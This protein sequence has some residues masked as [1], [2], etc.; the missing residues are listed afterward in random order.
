MRKIM[1]FTVLTAIAAGLFSSCEW[2]ETDGDGSGELRLRF[3]DRDVV[4]TRAATDIPDTNDFLLTVRSS[5]GKTLYEGA[6]GASPE[7]LLAAAGTYTV[8]AVSREFTSPSFSAPVYG[9]EQVVVVPSGGVATV[10]LTCRQ[11]NCGIKLSIGSSFLTSYPKGVLYVQSDKTHR[12]MYAYTEKRIAYFDPGTISVV[13]NDS[14]V[15]STLLSRSLMSQE[16]LAL[17]I[18]AG[19]S[20]GNSGT[21]T[22][23][24]GHDNG[25]LS[26]VVD[27]TRNWSSSSYILGSGEVSDSE[28]GKSSTNAY[29]VAGAKENIGET[30]V[31]V[32]GYIVGGDMTSSASGMKTEGPFSSAT[33]IAI[34]G[35]SSVTDKS[36][37]LSV[38]LPSGDIREALNLVNNPENLGKR[39]IIKGDLVASY[40]GVPGIKNPTD[41]VLK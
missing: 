10:E 33:N 27:T 7:S 13:L 24:E 8:K 34:A 36:S 14:G 32:S 25:G 1:V 26:I 22:G 17:S 4:M 21:A 16:I 31:W 12:L 30:E 37:C 9:D 19:T 29:T 39:L 35:R 15:S 5:T 40:Y 23:S 18:S 41:F 28:K 6:Y 20:S 38:Q 3:V 2:I 11:I